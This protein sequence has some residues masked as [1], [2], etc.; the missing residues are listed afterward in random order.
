MVLEVIPEVNGHL[1]GSVKVGSR[2]EETHEAQIRKPYFDL[3]KYFSG[4]EIGFGKTLKGLKIGFGSKPTGL[5]SLIG[6]MKVGSWLY[7][8]S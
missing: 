7:S 5:E 3:L 2:L 1:I 4:L 8:Q 6:S